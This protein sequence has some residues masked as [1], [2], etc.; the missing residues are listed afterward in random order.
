MRSR[1]TPAETLHVLCSESHV[2]QK[3]KQPHD[4]TRSTSRDPLLQFEDL[5][6]A[7][8]VRYW[9]QG[10]QPD[11]WKVAMKT[12][13]PFSTIYLE[14]PIFCKEQYRYL[15]HAET[16]KVFLWST[17]RKCPGDMF[18]IWGGLV[19]SSLLLGLDLQAIKRSQINCRSVA[20]GA[21]LFV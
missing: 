8:R 11:F 16:A 1:A 19:G 9:N 13:N 5:F 6:E 4:G 15:Q 10:R 18:R 14:N 21:V 3:E 7:D 2:L 12:A 17:V 20:M